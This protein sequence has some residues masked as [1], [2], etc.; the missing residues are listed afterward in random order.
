MK[1]RGSITANNDF[2]ILIYISKADIVQIQQG[3][4]VE[5]MFETHRFIV[6]SHEK[7]IRNKRQNSKLDDSVIFKKKFVYGTG[8]K[9][10]KKKERAVL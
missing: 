9:G 8:K 10:R 1:V 5:E 2:T 3:E 6:C 4:S 7:M